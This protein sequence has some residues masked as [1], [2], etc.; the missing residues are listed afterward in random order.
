MVTASQF[1]FYV[2]TELRCDELQEEKGNYD[3]LVLD[4]WEKLQ[5]AWRL[6]CLR[7]DKLVMK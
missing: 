3:K 4:I 7:G 5:F 2:R 6:G 1:Y